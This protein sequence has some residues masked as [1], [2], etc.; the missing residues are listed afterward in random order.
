MCP[1]CFVRIYLKTGWSKQGWA[2]DLG[3]R[4][5]SGS[6]RERAIYRIR[7]FFGYLRGDKKW[8]EIKRIGFGEQLPAADR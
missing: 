7:G 2:P 3:C 5:P 6:I 4:E 1:V 8:G